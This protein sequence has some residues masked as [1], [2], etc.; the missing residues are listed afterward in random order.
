[1]YDAHELTDTKSDKSAAIDPHGDDLVRVQY[2]DLVQHL[3]FHIS[4]M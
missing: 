4:S 3:I 2:P 1:M